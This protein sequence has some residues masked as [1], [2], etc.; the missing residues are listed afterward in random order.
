MWIEPVLGHSHVLAC[1]ILW[2]C[3]LI[4]KGFIFEVCAGVSDCNGEK[5]RSLMEPRH[6][7]APA[8]L[9]PVT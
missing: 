1:N 3:S 7:A 9:C 6:D 5:Q 8:R 4:A 2:P